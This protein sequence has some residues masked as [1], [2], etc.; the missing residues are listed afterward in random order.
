MFEPRH[1]SLFRSQKRALLLKLLVLAIGGFLP[2]QARADAVARSLPNLTSD[3]GA[4]DQTALPSLKEV[5]NF[6]APGT[7]GGV[8]W[9]STGTEVAAYSFGPGATLPAIISVPSAFASLITI[10]NADGTVFRELR[11]DKPFIETLDTFAFV[12]GDSQIVAPPSIYADHLAFSVFDIA[13]GE[14]VREVPGNIPGK[15]RSTNGARILLA[16]P[17]ESILAVG[18]GHATPQPVALYSTKNWKKLPDLQ[19]A[20][21]IGAQQPS[22]LAFSRHGRFLA[23]HRADGMVVIYDLN[24]RKVV[25]TVNPIPHIFGTSIA[26]SPD[27]TMI[28]FGSTSATFTLGDGT[29]PPHDPVRLF[30]IKDGSTVAIY[31]EPFLGGETIS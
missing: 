13:T 18:F 10:W 27:G 15:Q 2:A 16:S 19:D 17:D 24:S 20:T 3:A 23:V 9:N 25:Q 29:R 22:A 11:R 28:A 7:V 8:I 1:P 6:P 21:D 26:F 5:R 31:S 12:N 30:N 4:P 14:V